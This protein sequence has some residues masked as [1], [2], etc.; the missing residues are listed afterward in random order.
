MKKL[1]SVVLFA[2][3]ALPRTAFPALPVEVDTRWEKLRRLPT[4]EYKP[5]V[6]AFKKGLKET[7]S[8]DRQLAIKT[9]GAVED[10]RVIDELKKLFSHPDGSIRNTAVDAMGAIRDYRAAKELTRA[11]AR[12]NVA[13][14]D[15]KPLI[16]I[17]TSLARLEYW[18]ASLKIKKLLKSPHAD[19]KE[20]ACLTLAALIPAQ[21]VP[22]IIKA[23]EKD[24]K[25]LVKAEKRKDE[26]LKKDL[27]TMINAE[28]RALRTITGESF[29]DPGDYKKWWSRNRGIFE[30]YGGIREGFTPRP[31]KK[32]K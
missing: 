2:I 16:S 22:D 12:F 31:I 18:E 14:G 19:V 17:L 4:K 27:Q 26:K 9:F 21:Y 6:I 11:I 13:R 5:A 7:A 28:F 1:L 29:D 8:A 30:A 20:A 25:D 23:Y 15:R 24:K 3:L 10:F 32:P